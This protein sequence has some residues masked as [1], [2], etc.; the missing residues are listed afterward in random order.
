MDH[1]F[2]KS[3][4]FTDRYFKYANKEAILLHSMP[5]RRG[6][7]I[8]EEALNNPHTHIFDQATNVLPVLK[9]V[10]ALTVGKHQD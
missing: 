9:A 6:V 1:D 7:D 10:L 2:D 5:I 3:F 4:L 8:S